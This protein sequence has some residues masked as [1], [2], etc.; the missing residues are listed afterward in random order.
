MADISDEFLLSKVVPLSRELLGDEADLEIGKA[1]PWAAF[2]E[3]DH[4]DPEG[5]LL[6]PWLRVEI[7]IAYEK[8]Y[9]TSNSNMHSL[10]RDR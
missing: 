6:Q 4:A 7:I 5:P 3:H 1:V 9:Y 10:F 8:T 2:H